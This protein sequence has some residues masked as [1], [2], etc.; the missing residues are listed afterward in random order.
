MTTTHGT[1][2]GVGTRTSEVDAERILLA[3]RR[4]TERHHAI[5]DLVAE[6]FAEQPS[7]NCVRAAGRRL[8]ANIVAL[9][10]SIAKGRAA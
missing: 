2:P 7:A 8:C 9:A 1:P 4:T 3:A 5:L 6:G 10:D